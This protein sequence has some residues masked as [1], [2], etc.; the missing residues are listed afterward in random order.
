LI[1]PEAYPAF[2]LNEVINYVTDISDIASVHITYVIMNKDKWNMLSADEQK[3]MQDV[4]YETMEMRAKAQDSDLVKNSDAFKAT[5][6]KTWITLTPDELHTFQA[7]I[8][9]V[10]ESFMN[11]MEASGLPAQDYANYI[12]ER[13]AY[14]S[15]HPPM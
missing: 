8:E 4:A 3:I 1:S 12:R 9:P 5:E 2:K 11:G 13:L 14:W 15:A 7:Y 10:V 6:G